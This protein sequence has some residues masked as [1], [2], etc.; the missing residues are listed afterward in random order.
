[1]CVCVCVC[2]FACES[3]VCVCVC[4]CVCVRVL[5][6]CVCMCESAVC[7]C[8][9]E[10]SS[11]MAVH[12]FALLLYYV[13]SY[14]FTFPAQFPLI[15]ECWCLYASFS[16]CHHRKVTCGLATMLPHPQHLPT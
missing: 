14:S 7:V 3:F 1:M 15:P 13:L 4:V 12:V 5:C 8:V 11:K 9:R 6:V 10:T 16:L 2:V